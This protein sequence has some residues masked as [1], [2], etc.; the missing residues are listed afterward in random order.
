[1][2]NLREWWETQILGRRPE[3]SSLHARALDGRRSDVGVPVGEWN[4]LIGYYGARGSGK[5][6]AA[7]DHV[8][9]LMHDGPAYAIAHDPGNRVPSSYLD[10][11]P[12]PVR[13]H[14][15]RES[16]LAALR[17]D[18]PGGVH[19]WGGNKLGQRG[20]PLLDKYGDPM[21]VSVEDV[22]RL[23][24][25]VAEQ[26]KLAAARDAG[27]DIRD[28]TDSRLEGIRAIPVVV[29]VDEAVM[30]HGMQKNYMTPWMRSVLISLRHYHLGIVYCAQA[31]GAVH[32]DM[33]Q[34]ATE[35]YIARTRNK[36]AL[37][38][39]DKAGVSDEQL[40]EIQTVPDYEW[41]RV[42]IR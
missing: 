5:S 10:G 31:G 4:H 42:V 12:R 19:T 23:G 26:S 18:N 8:E 2:S 3:P 1:M 24:V 22:I 6:T 29:L 11:S 39:F 16:V 37:R 13:R 36:H 38:A 41:L 33:M 21:P 27:L 20:E 32:Y 7:A 9:R 28:A 30:S 15:T 14:R 40:Q 17:S 35:L 25:E 34:L